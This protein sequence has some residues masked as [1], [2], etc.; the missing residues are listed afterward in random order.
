MSL[1]V[2]TETWLSQSITNNKIIPDNMNYYTIYLKDKE[3]G[4]GGVM[5]AVSKCIPSFHLPNLDTSCEILWV[6][7]FATSKDMYVCWNLL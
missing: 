2:G 7:L 4:H 3:D 1:Y 5:I 6:K